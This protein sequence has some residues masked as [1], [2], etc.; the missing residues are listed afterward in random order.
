MEGFRIIQAIGAELV[1]PE[2]IV[3]RDAKSYCAILL[4]DNNRRPICRF[5][6]GKKKMTVIIFTPEHETR[7]DIEKLSQIYHSRNHILESIRRYEP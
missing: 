6:F 2:R 3:M 1:D 4:D 7:V 5:Y